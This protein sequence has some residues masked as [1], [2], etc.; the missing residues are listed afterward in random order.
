MISLP[1]SLIIFAPIGLVFVLLTR[2]AR[3]QAA[4]LAAHFQGTTSWLTDAVS[5]RYGG[6]RCTLR[7]LAG[8]GG[9][10]G[11]GYYCSLVLDLDGG[12]GAVI[13]P[14]EAVKY[15][16]AF[17]VPARHSWVTAGTT[18]LLVTGPAHAAI[19]RKLSDPELAAYLPRVFPRAYSTVKVKREVRIE[20]GRAPSVQWVMELTGMPSDVY[21]RPEVLQP[22]LDDVL[23]LRDL[24]T[25]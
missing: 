20:A 16:Y 1:L 12:P 24:V 18:R 5:F 19:A 11:G 14:A 13:A 4:P 17:S 15:V 25:G 8:G 9:V 23:R 2:R 10:G 7:R 6:A 21:E 22:V 3:Q